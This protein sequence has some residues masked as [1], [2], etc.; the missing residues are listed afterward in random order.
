M[1]IGKNEVLD[2]DPHQLETMH[3]EHYRELLEG[4]NLL[5]FDP[6]GFLVF[7]DGVRIAANQSQLDELIDYLNSQRSNMSR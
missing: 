7:G 4:D 6:A 5:W 3:I 2:V 1:S